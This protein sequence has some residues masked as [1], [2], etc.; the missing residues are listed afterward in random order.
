MDA[1]RATALDVSWQEC[2]EAGVC[3]PPQKQRVNLAG[4]VSEAPP[5][6]V[7]AAVGSTPQSVSSA[8]SDSSITRMLGQRT[9][10]SL[11]IAVAG[12]RF[13][14]EGLWRLNRL[15]ALSA[16][17]F[18]VLS[19]DITLF[20]DALTPAPPSTIGAACAAIPSSI[21]LPLP[22][23]PALPYLLPLDA[24]STLKGKLVQLTGDQIQLWDGAI[25]RSAFLNDEVY[26]ELLESIGQNGTNVVPVLV[27]AIRGS[28][29]NDQRPGATRYVLICG[30][31]RVRACQALGLPL[32]ALVVEPEDLD[33][34]SAL[35]HMLAGNRGRQHHT[36]LDIGRWANRQLDEGTFD[37]AKALC[38]FCGFDEGDI[39]K[40]RS[41]ATLP[42]QV[43]ESFAKTKGMQH[44]FAAPLAGMVATDL[45][46]LLSRAEK[47]T[48]LNQRSGFAMGAQE[49]FLKLLGT[50][51]TA[52][53]APR[54]KKARCADCKQSAPTSV[55]V[56]PAG[57]TK[58]DL[59][60]F[61]AWTVPDDSRGSVALQRMDQSPARAQLLLY[62]DR[63][64]D[65]DTDT[66]DIDI[67]IDIDIDA[68][69]D[70]S[71]PL[72][73]APER[74]EVPSFA[75]PSA[76]PSTSIPI[77]SEDGIDL[78]WVF[79]DAQGFTYIL[80][81]ARNLRERDREW[82]ALNLEQ[83]LLKAPYLRGQSSGNPGGPSA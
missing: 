69:A 12:Q 63:D 23:L 68:D 34:H 26:Q 54:E 13:L 4:S 3:Y 36:P 60:E 62:L 75:P 28:T 39:S 30:Q 20:L 48:E 74:A 14:N 82:I 78:G 49:V 56:G 19:R 35:R 38:E 52:T 42:P 80:I 17:A 9:L 32:Q 46:G 11:P 44:R 51:P 7:G 41:L 16:Q 65:T 64:T 53:A 31:L 67:D 18:L 55:V 70:G 59:N 77:V 27:R 8:G 43:I 61:R 47:V 79:T 71:Q 81:T 22:A 10:W 33:D 72:S 40:A 37:S 50:R 21:T 83:I 73:Q 5:A 1:A 25:G 66:D 24:L 58:V 45:Q 15:F 57:L 2:A 6:A 76:M 29:Q